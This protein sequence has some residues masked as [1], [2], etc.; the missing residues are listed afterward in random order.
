MDSQKGETQA[1]DIVGASPSVLLGGGYNP[2]APSQ[3]NF[4]QIPDNLTFRLFFPSCFFE[5]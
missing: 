3:E 2:A 5:V 1:I 4:T